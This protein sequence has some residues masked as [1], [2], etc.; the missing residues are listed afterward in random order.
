[1]KM[2]QG[3][4]EI[5][6]TTNGEF[7]S[8][9]LWHEKIVLTYSLSKYIILFIIKKPE[10]YFSIMAFVYIQILDIVCILNIIKHN[11]LCSSISTK[12]NI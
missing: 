11:K 4:L 5:E 12:Y 6:D 2:Y 7:A 1:M 8:L 9:T 3:V 10:V